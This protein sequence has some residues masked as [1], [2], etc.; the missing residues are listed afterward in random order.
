MPTT[1]DLA[2]ALPPQHLV[3]IS[4]LFLPHRYHHLTLPNP[5]LMEASQKRDMAELEKAL[6]RAREV[7]VNREL[8]LQIALASRLRDHLVKIDKLRHSVLNMES[9]TISEIKSYAKP[10]DGVHQCMIATFLLLGHQLKELKVGKMKRRQ[11]TIIVSKNLSPLQ[12]VLLSGFLS[13]IWN[14]N[15]LMTYCNTVVSVILIGQ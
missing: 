12:K 13:N 14:Y 8:D 1:L 2:L 5:D 15:L 10:P 6:Q 9:K 4:L 7:N 11:N 3:L